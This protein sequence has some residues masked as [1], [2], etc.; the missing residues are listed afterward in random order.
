MTL[1]HT[2]TNL[3]Q[4]LKASIKN[5]NDYTV[6]NELQTILHDPQQLPDKKIVRLAAEAVDLLGDI[7]LRL[8]PLYSS[9]SLLRWARFLV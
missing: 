8:E 9:R 3:I 4:D 1:E 7:D 2:L 6:V 5:L